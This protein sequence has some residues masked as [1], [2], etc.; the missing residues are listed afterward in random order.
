M[1]KPGNQIRSWQR[2]G[3]QKRGSH[4]GLQS[5]DGGLCEEPSAGQ[6]DKKG[7]HPI[8]SIR[9]VSHEPGDSV[10]EQLSE[11]S[12]RGRRARLQRRCALT[13]QDAETSDHD[14]VK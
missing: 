8:N 1:Q 2:D 3:C 14:D 6:C 10:A 5:Q 13:H 4:D 11:K 9:H 7:V 12:F